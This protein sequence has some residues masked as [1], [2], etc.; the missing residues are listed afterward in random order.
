[1]SSVSIVI[2]TYGRE[3]VLVETLKALLAIEAPADEILVVDETEQHE[4]TTVDFLEK[5]N[6]AG[7][8]RWLKHSS[9]SGQ[10]AKLNRGLAEAKSEIVLFLDDDVI[11]SKQ[12]VRAHRQVYDQY[13]EA[14]AVVGQ[15][16]QPGE[17]A[18]GS[19]NL[20]DHSKS[21]LRRDL[22]FRFNSNESAWVE[23]VITCNLSVRRDRAL[24]LNGFDVNFAPPVAFRAETDFAK[25]I[26]AAGGRIRFEPNASLKH[27]R[28]NRGGTRSVGQH[29]ASGSPVHGVGDYYFALKHGKGWDRI[30][31]IARRPFREVYT[32]FHLRQPW[33]IPIKFVG[34]LRAIRMASKIYAEMKVREDG[35]TT[36]IQ[37][38]CG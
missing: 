20:P 9:P 10:V 22:D 34:E 8:I 33:W 16:I 28:A 17:V 29:L 35:G 30:R 36:N 31:Y 1:M 23:N 27:L 7:R 19:V 26:V 14:W 37:T 21:L 3:E 38:D 13:P 12:L 2:A 11:P 15:V 5:A 32:K 4:L 6:L 24:A 18:G 25:R